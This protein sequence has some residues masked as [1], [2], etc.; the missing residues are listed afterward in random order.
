[1]FPFVHSPLCLV[2]EDQ[3]LI[4]MAMEATLE[5][6][7][8]RVAGPLVSNA[9]APASLDAH[10]PDLVLLHVLLKDGPCTSIVHALQKRSIPFAIYSG[11][12]PCRPPPELASVLWMEK[13]VPRDDLTSALWALVSK[14]RE[15]DD[16]QKSRCE[17]AE[18]VLS[19]DRGPVPLGQDRS[20]EL[21]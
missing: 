14:A 2:I 19:S 6:A 20:S 17:K 18:L 5:D 7:A 4:G 15:D 1:M 21:V 10:T 11:L 9:E 12:R 3:A 13:P 16:L 8:F